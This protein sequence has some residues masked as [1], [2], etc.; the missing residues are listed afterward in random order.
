MLVAI[1]AMAHLTGRV[2]GVNLCT[3]EDFGTV[4]GRRRGQRAADRAHAADRDVPVA[5]AAAQQ[6]VQKAHVLRQ[7]RVVGAGECADQCIGRHHAANQVVGHCL[8]DRVSDRLVDDEPPR[9]VVA[10]MMARLV[11]GRSGWVN[12]GHSREVTM[13]QRR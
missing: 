12:V 1:T 8:G 3:R 9:G 7:R 13:R 2:D 10:R 6:V 11:A 4:P 5:G